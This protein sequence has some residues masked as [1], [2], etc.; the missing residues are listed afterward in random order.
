MWWLRKRRTRRN[1]PPRQQKRNVPQ[2]TRLTGRQNTQ[3]GSNVPQ[4]TGLTGRHDAQKVF[5]Q[6]GRDNPQSGLTGR[7]DAQRVLNQFGRDGFQI[8]KMHVQRCVHAKN[9]WHYGPCF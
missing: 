2:T 6:F 7:R 3:V 1:V 8:E 5:T 9:I 4:T